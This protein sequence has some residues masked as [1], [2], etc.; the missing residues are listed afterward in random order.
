MALPKASQVNAVATGLAVA[1]GIPMT[2]LRVVAGVVRSPNLAAALQAVAPIDTVVLVT[3]SG[4]DDTSPLQSE[5]SKA[6]W[7]IELLPVGVREEPD[8]AAPA[9][10]RALVEARLKMLSNALSTPSALL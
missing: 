8:F 6:A 3:L 4:T 7:Y 9:I 10:L 5:V 2:I 1:P